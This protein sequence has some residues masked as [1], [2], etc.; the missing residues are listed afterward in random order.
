VLAR[1]RVNVDA[2]ENPV[3]CTI[4]FIDE[5]AEHLE[6]TPQSEKAEEK[7]EGK[8]LCRGSSVGVLAEAQRF[9]F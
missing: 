1:S 6:Q 9:R 4:F 3:M 7:T 8:N 5:V 2:R